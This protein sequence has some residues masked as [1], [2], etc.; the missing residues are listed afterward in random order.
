MDESTAGIILAGGRSTRMGGGDKFLRPLAGRPILTHVIARLGPQVSHLA[1]NANSAAALLAS[2]GLD[3]VPDPLS[4]MGPLGGVLAGLLWAHRQENAPAYIV[5]VSCDTPF[6]PRDLVARLHQASDQPERIIVARSGGM[7]HPTCAL[8]PVSLAGDLETFL[9]RE[10]ASSVRAFAGKRH[11]P[12]VADFPIN[13]GCDPF[14][15][16]NTPEDL[17]EAERLAGKARR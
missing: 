13:D 2:F 5:T 4:E 10:G 3:V 12:A 9:H 11:V 1:L 8:W 7:L 6:L 15:N 17:T 14:F 16:V